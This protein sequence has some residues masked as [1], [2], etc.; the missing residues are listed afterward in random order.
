MHGG[1]NRPGGE[2]GEPGIEGPRGPQITATTRAR[3]SSRTAKPVNVA[4]RRLS[5]SVAPAR[6]PRSR[7]ESRGSIL[8]DSR[9]S[10]SHCTVA[11][12]QSSRAHT[13]SPC[14]L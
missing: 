10:P 8:D 7:W 14:I 12:S 1:L 5:L 11:K 4:D 13:V 3:L 6:G 2:V 9:V